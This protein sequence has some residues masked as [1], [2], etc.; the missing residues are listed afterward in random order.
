MKNYTYQ[1]TLVSKKQL[2]QVLSW[3]FS[4]YGSIKACFLADELKYLGFKYATQAGI[5]ISIEDLRVPNV[6]NSMLQNANQEILNTEK[7]CLKGKITDVERFQKIIDTWNITSEL[8]KDEVVSYFK[9]YDPLNSVYIMAFSGARGNLSQ[10]RQLV[11]MRGLMSD[12]SGEIMNLPIK[13]NFREGL[14]ITDYLMSGYGARKGIVDTALKTANSGYLTRRLIDVA[15]D[16]IIREK[17]CLTPHSFLLINLK[18]NTQDIQSFYERIIGRLLNKPVYNLKT[19]ELIAEINTQITPNLI[20]TFKQKKIEKFYI[21]SPLTCS[22]YR[23]ICQKCYGWDLASENLVDMGEAIGIIAGQSIGEPGTQLTMR[24]FHTGG[25]FTSE[26]NQQLISSISGIIEFSKVL[27]TSTLRTNRGENVLLTE[28][29]GSLSIIPDRKNDQIIQLELPRNTILFIKD[30]QYVKQNVTLGQ[31][32]G[33]IKQTRTETKHILSDSSGEIFM[34]KLKRKVNLTTQNKLLWILSGQVYQAPMNSFLNF[35]PDYKINKNSYIFRSKIINQHPGFISLIAGENHLFEQS[36]RINSNIY[37]LDNSNIRKLSS[38]INGNNYLLTIQNFNYLIDLKVKNSKFFIPNVPQNDFATSVTN[39]FT[40]LTGGIPY[41]NRKINRKKA[42]Y[43]NDF[44]Y[45]LTDIQKRHYRTL[46]WLPEETHLLNCDNSLLLIEPHSFIS[47]NFEIV[48]NVYSQTSGIVKV[49]EKNNFIQEISIKPGVVYASKELKNLDNQIFFPGEMILNTIEITQPSLCEVIKVGLYSQLLIRPLEIYEVPIPKSINNLFDKNLPSNS[50]FYLTNQLNY[51]YESGQKIKKAEEI[52]LVTNI[53]DFKLKNAFKKN[54]K[55]SIE[56]I[57]NDKKN[58]LNFLLTEKLHLIDYLPPHLKYT[59]IQSC[60]IVESTQFVNAHTI[61]G[62]L[63]VISLQSLELV[64]FKSK[65]KQNKQVFLISNDN[66]ITIEKDKVQN[67]TINDFLIDEININQTGKIIIDNGKFVTVQKGRP[68]FFPNCKNDEFI[69]DINLTYRWIPEKPLQINSELSNRKKININYSDITTLLPHYVTFSNTCEKVDFPKILL[70]KRGNSYTSGIPI[71][72][73]EFLITKNSN[74]QTKLSKLDHRPWYGYLDHKDKIYKTKKREI[75][76]YMERVRLDN[77][78]MLLMKSSELISKPFKPKLKVQQELASV[79]LLEHPFRTIGI[80]SITE[81]YFE[82]EVNS[83]F[84]KNGEF[85]ENGQTIGL[86]NFEKEI[87]GDIVQGLP[88]IEE[89]LEARKKKRVSK[90]TPKNQKKGLLIRKTTIDPT[91]EFRKIGTTIKDNEKINPHSLLKIYF[92]Y[93]AKVKYMICHNTLELL[94]CRLADNYEA[95]YRS[96]KKIQALI[97][98]SVQSVYQ[99]QGVT[100][101]DKH[102]E[103]II[104][105]MT[106]K[107]LITHEGQTPL[108]PREVIDLYHIKYINQ[109]V[110]T[111]NKQTACYVPLLL[112]ITK[113]ALNNPSFISAASFQETTR[114]LTKAAIEGRVDWLRGLKENIIIGHLIPSGTGTQNYQNCF[115]TNLMINS[116]LKQKNLKILEK[117]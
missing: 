60:L 59:E 98:N 84:C 65:R 104:K 85:V 31:L 61:L 28:S 74:P 115:N 2:K 62:Y 88:R 90:H 15:Q 108:L 114:V 69:N 12:P 116:N 107:V 17:D 52:N 49:N 67:K 45:F 91:F 105:Q 75:L 83:V 73:R 20:R 48:P 117:I 18:N 70:K 37:S 8:L 81:D 19:N 14:T 23:S 63:E 11:G 64:K 94:L 27:K 113:A 55:M 1:N 40:S 80:H 99:S 101:A 33:N 89:L 46:L 66:C 93:Y 50:I 71:F 36:I 102:L 51:L 68:Y 3:S 96:F 10:V 25:I 38:T 22:L 4:K 6:K 9:Q 110:K 44:V 103:I 24:T 82:Q 53:L 57:R 109:V 43:L 78:F 111:Q 106:T 79:A 29:S 95:S 87:T 97:L 47:E 112:G 5:S 21:R 58:H 13:K 34:P 77:I 76:P 39:Q 41:Y 35:Y 100:I 32:A 26:A 30:K 72:V 86:L 54:D 56:I 42:A 16:I 7:I 92:N